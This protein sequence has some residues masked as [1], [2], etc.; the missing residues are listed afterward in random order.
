MHREIEAGQ[1]ADTRGG[2][3]G[4]VDDDPRRDHS[5]RRRHAAHAAARDV[6]RRHFDA[7]DDPRSELPRSSRVAVGHFGR[8]RHPVV[9][10]P[11]GG[12]EIVDV[13]RGDEFFGVARCDDANVDAE[14]LL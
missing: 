12:E 11:H 9:R 5:G 13:E 4:G 14:G 1:A 8:S 10:A 3:P 2:G 6:N 7:F